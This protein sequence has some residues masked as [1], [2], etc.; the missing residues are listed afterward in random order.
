MCY[1]HKR[2]VIYFLKRRQARPPKFHAH[3]LDTCGLSSFQ[4]CSLISADGLVANLFIM[5]QFLPNDSSLII[6]AERSCGHRASRPELA[7]AKFQKEHGVKEFATG[8]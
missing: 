5:P 8:M 7:R 4:L 1:L 6:L 2:L 3:A